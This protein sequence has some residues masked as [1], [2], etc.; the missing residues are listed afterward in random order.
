VKKLRINNPKKTESLTK[1]G[2]KIVKIQ[3]ILIDVGGNLE[4][5]NRRPEKKNLV[6]TFF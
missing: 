3:S 6:F 5:K 2:I 1:L 4:L